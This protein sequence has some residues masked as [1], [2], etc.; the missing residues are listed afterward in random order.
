MSTINGQM[1]WFKL[2]TISVWIIS[3]QYFYA[4]IVSSWSD[5]A[6]QCFESKNNAEQSFE[7]H[8]SKYCVVS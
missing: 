6:E 2:N 3:I 1:T 8:L 4:Q 7:K 5:E